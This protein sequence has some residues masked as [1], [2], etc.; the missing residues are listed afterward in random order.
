MLNGE[1]VVMSRV[2]FMLRVKAGKE[3]EYK[4]RHKT[5]WPELVDAAKKAGIRNHTV[6]LRG[7]DLFVY[8]EADDFERAWGE[9]LKNPIK[10]KW[11]ELMVP[12]FEPVPDLKEGEAI[13]F[14]E[15]VFHFD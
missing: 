9:L 7:Q 12:L 4:E 8:L 1:D 10:A 14:M 3:E 11:D 2:A 5:V 15:E 6:F 13:A